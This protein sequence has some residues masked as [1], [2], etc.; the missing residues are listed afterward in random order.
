MSVATFRYS[1]RGMCGRGKSEFQVNSKSGKLKPRYLK[2]L[3]N[4]S[5]GPAI[6]V[7]NRLSNVEEKKR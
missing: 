4:T 5:Q 6:Q 3:K 2:Y 7:G 1:D